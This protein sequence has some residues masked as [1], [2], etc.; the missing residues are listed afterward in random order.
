L[1]DTHLPFSN[2]VM[3]FPMPDKFKMPHIKKYDGSK[4]PTEHVE[5]F[6]ERF[7]LHG[8]LDEI[9]CRAFPLTLVRVAKD[10]FAR[11]L[12]KSVDKFKDLGYLFLA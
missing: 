3:A 10:W 4:D 2:L 1:E 8:T 7:I 6:W 11:L 12:I 9:A 5:N